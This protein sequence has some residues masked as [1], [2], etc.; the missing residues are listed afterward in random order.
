M[1]SDGA[2]L[3][4]TWF[5]R[6]GA[7]T[8]PVRR[9][10]SP[11]FLLFCGLTLIYVML[12]A[13]GV[14]STD[15]N[16][17]FAVAYS[18]A[19]GLHTSVRCSVG[20]LH[21]AT[22]CYSEWYPL[23]SFLAAP[24]VWVGD[25]MGRVAGL[26]GTYVAK[27][28]ALIVPAVAGAGAAT[29][30]AA[31]AGK[32][33]AS[34]RGMIGAAVAVAFGTEMLT[35][36]RTF[37]AETLAAC[38]TALAVWAA[39]EPG[40]RRHLAVG[41]V[42]LA[43]LAK[44]PM[45][46]VGPALGLALATHQRSWRPALKLTA[47]SLLGLA[48]YMLYNWLRVHNALDFGQ[49]RFTAGNYEPLSMVKIL[50]LLL[51]SPGR[52]L[53]WYS[54][55][56][57]LGAAGLW[58]HRRNPTALCCI[59]VS[60]AVLLA[61]VSWP[62][63]GEDWGDRF[64]VPALPLLC[65]S[66][67]LFRGSWRRVAAVLVLLCLVGQIPTTLGF[68]ERAFAEHRSVHQSKAAWSVPRSPIVTAWPAM[69]DEVRDA[70]NTNVTS[71]VHNAGGARGDSVQGQ[72]LLHVVALWWWMLPAIGVPWWVGLAFALCVMCAGVLLILRA[73]GAPGSAR[74]AYEFA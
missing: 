13:P 52:G 1:V 25:E 48:L 61:Y 54:P 59:S 63:G 16:S 74:S 60:I 3:R 21:S 4:P 35:Y 15:G 41:A 7:L 57:V 36:E 11:L 10:R 30:C 9:P 50:G 66:I 2:V 37:F 53:L 40:R 47:A 18:L 58:R 73:R 71:I 29:L 43:V 39:T 56:A 28:F 33:G 19:N 38:L 69:V 49:S 44:P 12:L 8:A 20:F 55:V 27:E 32:L 45:F 24:L 72:R 26:N 6:V 68:F 65:A 64:L 34:R 17:M 67:G 22:A 5:E 70:A 23:L 31:L 42:A 51:I 62:Y 14:Y 46:V